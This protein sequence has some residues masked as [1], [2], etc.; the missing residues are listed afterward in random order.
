VSVSKREIEFLY[1]LGC[2]R[3]IDRMWK[4]FLKAD[5]ANLADHHFRVAWTALLIARHEG[6]KDTE[7]VLKMALLHDLAESR[8]GDVD[9]LARQYTQRNEELGL[10][11]MVAGTVFQN[12]LVELMKEYEAHNTLEA[13][14]VKDADMLDVDIELKEQAARGM[15]IATDPE[16]N[17]MRKFVYE[18]QLQTKTAKQIWRALQASNPHDWHR[19][20]RN[21]LNAGD[22]KEKK[23]S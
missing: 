7:K 22:W 18:N 8:T 3:F 13:R 20:G 21:R 15:T 12:E 5:F 19:K 2:I 23:K 11:D 17:K 10:A 1:E 4:R 9:Y 6:V 16:W 14:I